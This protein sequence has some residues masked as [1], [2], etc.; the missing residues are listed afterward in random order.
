MTYATVPQ[1]REYVPQVPA[2]A[3]ED[4]E[5]QALLD[6][7]ESIVNGELGFEFADYGEAEARHGLHLNAPGTQI[8]WIAAH[9]QGTVASVYR[10]DGRG[11]SEETETEV[12]DWAEMDDGRLWRPAGWLSSWYKITA[13]WGYGPAPDAIVEVTLE[14]AVNIWRGRDASQWGDSLGAEGGGAV[15]YRRALTW[16]QRAIIDNVRRQYV[17]IVHA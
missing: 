12:T 11:S 9:Q 7:A 8:L 15:M 5:L 10:V 4:A 14:V 16:A 1:L 3:E 17:G 6:R 13:V 2:G